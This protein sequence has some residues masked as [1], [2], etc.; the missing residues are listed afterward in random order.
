MNRLLLVAALIAGFLASPAIAQVKWVS[1]WLIEKRKNDKYC[2]AS[3][4]YKD[5]AD[6]NRL[7]G[8]VLTYSPD[9]IVM[10]LFYRGWEW[11]KVGDSLSVDLST[12]KG[13]I[14]MK[15]STWTVLDKTAIRGV[16]DFDQKILDGFSGAERLSVDV[17]DDEND[18]IEVEIPRATDMLA[19][20][21]YCQESKK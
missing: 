4:D 13:D 17:G 7:Y 3:R 16:F 9:R 10:V 2:N 15:K 20:L 6:E 5:A 19:A 14:I 12:D 21:R 8:F 18:S 1:G 11:E